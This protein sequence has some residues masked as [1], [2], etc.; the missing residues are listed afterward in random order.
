MIVI[1][2]ISQQI[3]QKNTISKISVLLYIL[4]LSNLGLILLGLSELTFMLFILLTIYFYNKD[5]V[6]EKIIAGIF[7]FLAY[8]TR[9][10]GLLLLLALLFSQVYNFYIKKQLKFLFDKNLL[11]FVTFI[12]CLM[13]YGTIN[14]Y[15]SGNFIVSGTTSSI[16]ILM[17]ANDDATG[18]YNTIFLEKGKIGYIKNKVK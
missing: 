9:E 13:L 4:S 11:V 17:G 8:G 2:K 1:Y 12:C 5:K 3:F 6:Y 14:F 10:S 7:L 18:T 15:Y 16:N